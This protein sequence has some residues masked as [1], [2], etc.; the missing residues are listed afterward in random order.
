VKATAGEVLSTDPEKTVFV[1][2]QVSYR[3]G[4][5]V[6]MSA[7]SQAS[8]VLTG[9]ANADAFAVVPRG[10]G[11]VKEGDSVTLELFRALESRGVDDVI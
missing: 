2:V 4:M 3:D 5:V 10:V 9:A 11:D 8:N 6:V 1:R 7:G